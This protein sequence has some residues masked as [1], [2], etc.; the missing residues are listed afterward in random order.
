MK[1]S[2]KCPSPPPFSTVSN[3]KNKSILYFR[4]KNQNYSFS[5]TISHNPF[6]L[7]LQVSLFMLISWNLSDYFMY[8]HVFISLIFSLCDNNIDSTTEWTNE[9]SISIVAHTTFF[10]ILFQFSE[11]LTRLRII[12]RSARRVKSTIDVDA[13]TR[14]YLENSCQC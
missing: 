14:I 10:T 3:I 13:R 11:D 6:Y 8:L 2:I 1:K 7:S 12:P 4:N 5:C 9:K